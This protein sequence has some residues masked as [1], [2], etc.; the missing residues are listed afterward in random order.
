VAKKLDEDGDNPPSEDFETREVTDSSDEE[1]RSSNAFKALS[2]TRVASRPPA[3][4]ANTAARVPAVSTASTAVQG[5]LSCERNRIQVLEDDTAVEVT[6][7][8]DE[9]SSPH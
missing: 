3:K 4:R 2:G 9:V 7:L 1:I 5:R 8:P 6:L